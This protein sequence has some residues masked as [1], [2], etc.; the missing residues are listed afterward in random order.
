MLSKGED[1]SLLEE[2]EWL[3]DLAFLT[4]LTKKLN[5]LNRELQGKDK[6]VAHM[7]SAVNAFKA[8]M[9]IF[10]AQVEKKKMLHF[11]SVQAVLKDNVSASAA[12]DE[13]VTKYSQ[14]INRLGQ[15]LEDR[16]CDFK[17]LEPCVSFV[18]N[19][20][21]YVDVTSTAKQ[22]SDLFSLSTTD[23][24]MEIL[25]LQND[26]NLKAHQSAP[27][28]WCLVDREKYSGVCTAAMKIASFF[29]STYRCESA[30]SNMNFIKNKHRTRLTDAHLQDSLRIAV[31]NYSPDYN[32]LVSS[33]QCQASH[34]HKK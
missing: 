27:N 16:F 6:T 20:F 34:F 3:L 19:P 1:A 9:N 10:S 29:G 8:K 2:P 13:V 33:M 21:M 7:I 4:D 15:E 18:T 12:L 32:A 17:K 30:F 31:S 24:E 11:S 23:V 22:L 28:F 25:T 14:V 5:H 26:I